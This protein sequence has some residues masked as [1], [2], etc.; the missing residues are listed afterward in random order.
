MRASEEPACREKRLRTRSVVARATRLVAVAALSLLLVSG[1]MLWLAT[2]LTRS[3]QPILVLSAVWLVPVAVAALLLARSRTGQRIAKLVAESPTRLGVSALVAVGFLFT[4]LP[5]KAE[6]R[7]MATYVGTAGAA[8]VLFLVV[9]QPL[10]DRF[11]ALL[12]PAG[13]SMLHR[14]K[15]ALFLLLTS[16]FVLAITNLIS[17]HVFK[18]I[19]H[20]VDSMGQILQG[21]IF[22]SGHIT[23]PVRFDSYFCG[24]PSVFNDGA[25]MFAQYPFGHSLLLALGT[26][27]GAEWLVNPLL[28]AAEIVVLYFLGKELYDEKTGRIAALLGVASPF[29][30]FMS[31]EYMNHSSALLFISL[32]LLFFFRT[33]RPLRDTKAPSRLIDPLLSGLSLAMALNIRPLSALAVAAP[34]ACYAIYLLA[35]SKGKALSSFLVLLVPVMLGVVA[36]GLYNYLTTGSPWLSG[37]DVYGM[38]KDLHPRSGLGFGPRGPIGTPPHTPLRGLIQTG[39]NLNALNLYLFEGPVPGLLLVLL[40]FVTFPRNPLDWVL[41]VSFVAL[42]VLYFFYWSQGLIFGPR[43]LFEGL[44]PVLVLSARGLTELPGFVARAAGTRAGDR[45]RCSI[46]IGAALSLVVTGT[47]GLPRLLAVY[48]TRYIGV[49]DAVQASVARSGM[50]SAVVFVGPTSS[51]N[52]GAAVL[53]NALDFNGPVVY[54]MDRGAENYL[55]MQRLPGR[56]YYYVDFDTFYQMTGFESLRA[57]PDIRDL[58]QAGQ[59]LRLHETQEYRYVLLPYREAGVFVD[60]GT[61]PCRTFRELSYEL[62]RDRFKARDFLPAIAVFRPGDS[63]RY[64]PLFELMRERRDYVSDGCRF[65]LLFSADSGRAVVYSIRSVCQE[66]ADTLRSSR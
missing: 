1:V 26:L 22:A 10:S 50:S 8:F 13:R 49:D 62:I 60:T 35:R 29:L 45:V 38:L 20:V 39:D 12:R 48:G 16:G 37:Y 41:L 40:L 59:F 28:G 46:L 58:E 31:S 54:A 5:W 55:L 63:R 47:V 17:W 34:L 44:A 52:A 65:T 25:R 32:F 56:S 43:F 21:R 18:H 64:L 24:I 66:N 61:T 9:A 11:A 19:P 23:L 57:A 14:S 2:S 36:F 6:S 3:G 27:A 42:P 30:V 51:T 15:P 33:I 53:N 7:W 4:L